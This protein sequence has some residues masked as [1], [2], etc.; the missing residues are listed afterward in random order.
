VCAHTQLCV[1]IPCV[2]VE[3]TSAAGSHGDGDSCDRRFCD[4]VWCVHVVDWSIR[5]LT[6]GESRFLS[7]PLPAISLPDSVG[8]S[9]CLFVS[10]SFFFFCLCLSAVLSLCLSHTHTLSLLQAFICPCLFHLVLCWRDLGILS[11]SR[12]MS[13]VGF[14]LVFA[15]VGTINVLSHLGEGGGRAWGMT[16]TQTHTL[17]RSVTLSYHTHRERD[18]HMR[19]RMGTRN[20]SFSPACTH[21]RRGCTE[22]QKLLSSTEE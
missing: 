17:T 21:S 16:H 12:D 10:L 14:G 19:A 9:V 11:K 22:H 20:I 4:A 18:T 13:I 15:V 8:L 6:L 5:V 3:E 7:A 2:A 1:T